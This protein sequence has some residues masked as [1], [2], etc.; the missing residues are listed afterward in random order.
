MCVCVYM[1]EGPGIDQKTAPDPLE[2]KL[3]VVVSQA[4]WVLRIKLRSSTRAAMFLTTEPSPY[5]QLVIL[6]YI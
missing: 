6:R 5:P 2:P 3:Q 4:M 1:T